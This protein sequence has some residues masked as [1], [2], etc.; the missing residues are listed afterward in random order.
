MNPDNN[1]PDR[2]SSS[3]ARAL[4]A[5]LQVLILVFPHSLS[6]GR[7]EI[8]HSSQTGIEV[9]CISTTVSNLDRSISF[10]SQ[11]LGFKLLGQ[12]ELEGERVERLY[13][14][15]AAHLKTARLALGMEEIELIEFLAPAGK[16]YPATS[17]SNDRWFQ[18]FAIVTSDMEMA[19]QR[20]RAAKVEYASSSPQRLPDWNKAAAGIKAFYFK[21]PDGHPL[22][23]LEFPENKGSDRWHIRNG[24]LFLGIDHTAIVVAST[25]ASLKF[26]RD[27]LGM[28]VV[29]ESENYGTEQEHLNAIFGARL[30]ITTLRPQLGPG[31][32]L[33]E[34]LSPRDGLPFPSDE[35]TNDIVHRQTV[36][37][38][39]DLKSLEAQMRV[40]GASFISPDGQAVSDGSGFTGKSFIVR[41]P[42]GHAVQASERG[43]N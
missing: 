8:S 15:F 5:I 30:H 19:Y 12:Q 25:A 17:K 40:S 37:I 10:Y 3:F 38:V 43:R 1:R 21:D 31:V 32:E 7:P 16:P 18:H 11:V 41:D 14:V 9:S 33:L 24:E 36:F 34:Y 35:H 6:A 2:P 4:N 23:I 29:G 13:G 20:L 27:L 39:G 42:D 26:Y 22:E 28:T